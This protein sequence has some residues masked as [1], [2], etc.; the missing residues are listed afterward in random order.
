[1]TKSYTEW[2]EEALERMQPT[3]ICDDMSQIPK[4]WQTCEDFCT[5]AYPTP[6]CFYR[7]YKH[8]YLPGRGKE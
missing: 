8:I 5:N 3:W 2:L 6:E 7:L 1:M 4:E